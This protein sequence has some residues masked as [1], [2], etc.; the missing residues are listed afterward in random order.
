MTQAFD[1][2]SDILISSSSSVGISL[3]K[4]VKSEFLPFKSDGE[5]PYFIRRKSGQSA[6]AK[7]VRIQS[8]LQLVVSHDVRSDHHDHYQKPFTTQRCCGV[9]H[10]NI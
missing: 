1:F 2:K 9:C 7:I 6:S 8:F 3:S 4:P 5:Q 10:K